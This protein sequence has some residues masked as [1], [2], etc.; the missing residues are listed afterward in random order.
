MQKYSKS[1]SPM[2]VCSCLALAM[3]AAYFGAIEPVQAAVKLGMSGDVKAQPRQLPP[4]TPT[5]SPTPP[6]P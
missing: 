6:E 2:I 3:A 5:P 1:V 4:C